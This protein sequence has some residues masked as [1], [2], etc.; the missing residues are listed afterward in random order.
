MKRLWI[1][2]AL[3]A[4]LLA[5]SLFNAFQINALTEQLIER[6]PMHL[7]DPDRLRAIWPDFCRLIE[8]FLPTD[9]ALL[10]CMRRAGAPTEW[11]DVHVDA[12]LL[13]AALRYHPFM[14]YRLM[15]TRLLPMMGLDI[16]DYVD[17]PSTHED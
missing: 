11:E 13:R 16:L 5:L 15:P 7:V 3:L 10:D 17:L 8:D 4:A 14:R 6:M 12:P 2:V 1:A 9:E